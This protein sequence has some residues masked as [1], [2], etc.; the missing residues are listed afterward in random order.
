MN[1]VL[2]LLRQFFGKFQLWVIVVPW[3]QAIRVRLGRHTTLLCAGIHVKVPFADAVYMQTTRMRTCPLGRQTVTNTDGQT[4][5]FSASVGYA[6]GNILKLYESLHHAE[7]YVAS[8]ARAVV[9]QYIST[10]P[11]SEC[12]PSMIEQAV[13]Q[14]L[15]LSPFGLTDARLFLGDY[16]V[17]RTYRIVGD[18]NGFFSGG[19]PL[20]TTRSLT[21]QAQGA[22]AS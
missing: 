20:D 4:I 22:P 6:I 15:D 18:Y 5:T 8:L 17:V 11:S 14:Q 16:A 12:T 7:D 2:S 10:H 3:Q 19:M 9:A 21:E 13:T 1:D